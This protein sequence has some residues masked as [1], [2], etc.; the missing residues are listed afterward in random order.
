M[1]VAV[2]APALIQFKIRYPDVMIEMT[3]AD[4]RVFDLLLAA[5]ALT[6]DVCP[7]ILGRAP[8]PN[9]YP[10]GLRTQLQPR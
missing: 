3:L 2:L 4:R 7:L 8:H 10:F 5:S 1:A 6:H 9:G